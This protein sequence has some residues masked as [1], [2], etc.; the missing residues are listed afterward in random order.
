[1]ARGRNRTLGTQGRAQASEEQTNEQSAKLATQ[2][3]RIAIG[4]KK[5]QEALLL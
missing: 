5:P 2:G 3:Y 1:M 4:P